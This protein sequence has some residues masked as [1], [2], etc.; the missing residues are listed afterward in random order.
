LPPITCTVP[1]CVVAEAPGPVSV[2]LF[3]PTM[4]ICEEASVHAIVPVTEPRITTRRIPD[5]TDV[6]GK[7]P[8]VDVTM[9]VSALEAQCPSV[10]H[11]PGPMAEHSVSAVHER[12]AFVAVLQIGVAPEHVVLSV[13]C[14]HAPVAEHAGLVASAA[15]H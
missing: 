11:T 8:L 2:P 5:G 10:M 14:T 15:A 4:V 6:L 3:C 12:Q 9:I 7:L 13:H 1:V